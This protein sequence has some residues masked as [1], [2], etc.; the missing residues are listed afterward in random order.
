[1][2]LAFPPSLSETITVIAYVYIGRNVCTLYLRLALSYLLM[3]IERWER[4]NRNEEGVCV[5]VW[6]LI[7][8]PKDKSM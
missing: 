6:C 3:Y 1:M 2:K 7:R 8:L 4:K 5:T